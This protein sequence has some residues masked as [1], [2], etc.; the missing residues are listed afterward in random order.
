M[1]SCIVIHA[2]CKPVIVHDF[3]NH[4]SRN[5]DFFLQWPITELCCKHYYII[6]LNVEIYLGL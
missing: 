1:H 4:V 6:K 2:L 3:T 5:M